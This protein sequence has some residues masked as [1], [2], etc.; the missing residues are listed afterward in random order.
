MR[1]F[2]GVAAMLV[3]LGLFTLPTSAFAQANIDRFS[4]TFPVGPEP[5]DDTCAGAGV[6]GI[7]TGTG[8]ISGQTVETD[9]G[10]H[11]SGT[12]TIVFRADFPD[13]S[14]LA[15]SQREP[16]TFNENPLT[17]HVTFGG[18]LLERGTLYDADGTVIAHEIFHARF[19]A[20]IVAGSVV[21]EFDRGFL[22]CR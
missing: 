14:Y 10:F 2:A 8:T 5:I 9:T 13:G 22:T 12:Q 21:V 4:V 1:R 15:A 3:A 16:L 7:A 20:T 11:F 19:R 6:V 17:G 18:T